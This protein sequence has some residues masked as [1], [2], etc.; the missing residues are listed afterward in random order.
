MGMGRLGTTGRE[1]HKRCQ[2][3]KRKKEKEKENGGP[4]TQR[5][6]ERVAACMSTPYVVCNYAVHRLISGWR[7]VRWSG[8]EKHRP[9]R[10]SVRYAVMYEVGSWSLRDGDIGFF[11]GWRV[12]EPADAR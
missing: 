9:T 7:D 5:D 4:T 2:K 11:G 3:K 6:R 12:V 10:I 8:R 1:T